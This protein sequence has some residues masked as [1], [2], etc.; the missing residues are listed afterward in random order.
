MTQRADKELIKVAI[1]NFHIFERFE[2]DGLCQYVIFLTDG[3]L[4]I[5]D[6]QTRL[7][8]LIK[9]HK[10]KEKINLPYH[11]KKFEA[12]PRLALL[13]EILEKV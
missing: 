2:C 7:L 13:K 9:E 6:E 1:D 4:T 10:P 8:E 11:F 12:A 3:N 5:K